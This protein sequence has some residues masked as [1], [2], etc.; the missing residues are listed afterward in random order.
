MNVG[1]IPAIFEMCPYTSIVADGYHVHYAMIQLAFRELKGKLYLITDAVTSTLD[2]IYPHIYKENRYVMPDG[3][4]SGSALTM[5]SAVANVVNHCHVPLYD[6]I[7]M[8]S[9]IPATVVGIHRSKG[10][11]AVG[12]DAD[13]VIFDRNFI[14]QRTYIRAQCKYRYKRHDNA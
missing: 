5:L 4:L 1:C 12:Y 13:L 11:I 8:A 2:G 10:K 14:V 9:Y 6:A 3:T 7:A